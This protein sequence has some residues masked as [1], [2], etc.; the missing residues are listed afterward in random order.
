MAH[1]FQFPHCGQGNTFYKLHIKHTCWCVN[2]QEVQS[3]CVRIRFNVSHIRSI[4]VFRVK[5]KYSGEIRPKVGSPTLFTPEVE[6][7]IALYMKHCTFLRIPRSR[8]LLK[9][10]ILHYVQ[11]KG[12][13][14]KNLSEDGPVMAIDM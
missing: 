12:L 9:E 11:F 1:T 13:T 4:F 2:L 14:I 5:G 10:D 7:D 6:A 3:S 8:Q